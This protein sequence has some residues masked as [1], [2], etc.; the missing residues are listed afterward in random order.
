[1]PP[2]KTGVAAFW[3]NT[4]F[5]KGLNQFVQGLAK[6]GQ[7]AGSSGGAAGGIKQFTEAG[8][9]SSG[10][11]TQQI[12]LGVLLGNIYTRLA[13][14]VL[15]A[16]KSLFE[17]GKGAVVAAARVQTLGLVAQLL[18]QRAGYTEQQINDQTAA[19]KALG[20]QTDVA[21]GLQAQFARYN[22]DLAQATELARVAQ[23]AAVLSNENSS[24]ALDGLLQ[25]II[26]YNQRILRTHGLNVD[27]SNAQD[28]LAASLGKTTD[29]LTEQEKVQAALNGV[30]QAGKAIYGVY[31]TA[32]QTAGKQAKSLERLFYELKIT[33]G[34][35]FLSAFS[36]VI[37]ALTSLVKGFTAAISEGGKLYPVITTLGAIANI[38][39]GGIKNLADAIGGWLSDAANTAENKVSGIANEAINWG[40]N[41][42]INLATGLI[43]GAA[44]AI[45]AAL[46]WI[47]DLI[48]SWLQPG[49][50]PK[51]LPDLNKYGQ[52]TMEEYLKS[53]ST[54]DFSALNAIQ[55]QM[56]SVFGLL[57]DQGKLAKEQMGPLFASISKDIIKAMS[58]GNVDESLFKKIKDA[59]GQ[60]GDEL[61][62]LARKQI[63]LAQ[64]EEKVKAAE[65]ALQDA[66]KRQAEAGKQVN[67]LT[68][69]Y[70]RMLRGGASAEELAAQKAKI[71][72]SVQARDAAAEEA[73]QAQTNLDAAKEN[74]DVLKEQAQLQSELLQQLIELA[75]AKVQP[76]EPTTP[77]GGGAGGGTPPGGTSFQPPE[78]PDLSNLEDT[79]GATVDRIK[80]NILD[81]LGNV[82]SELVAMW[83]ERMGPSM[84]KLSAAWEA[85]KTAVAPVVA[86]LKQKW[87]EFYN[88]LINAVPQFLENVKGWWAKHGGNLIEIGQ[89]LWKNL[90]GGL[91]RMWQNIQ[92]IWE[93]YGGD[94]WQ[95]M[96]DVWALIV[97]IVENGMENIGSFIDLISALIKGDWAG[98]WEAVKSIAATGWENIKA[99]LKLAWDVI[100]LAFKIV[101]DY[102][103][104]YWGNIWNGIKSVAT[105]IWGAIVSA[106]TTIWNTII[107]AITSAI[108][109][110]K[111][112]LETAWN[113]ILLTATTIWNGI[114]TFFAGIWL[115]I[116]TA[117]QTAVDAVSGIL[118]AAWDT[119]KLAVETVWNGINTFLTDLIN[120]IFVWM[121][122]SL[123]EQKALWS[124]RLDKIWLIISTIWTRIKDWIIEK[125]GEAKTW[126][127]TNL[128]ALKTILDGIWTSIQTAA[129]T[130]WNA[131]STTAT[132]I[133]DTIKKTIT[134]VVD[135][136]KTWL[137]TTWANIQTAAETVWGLISGSAT[138][139]WTAIQGAIAGP[140][141]T[142]V[143]WL[144]IQWGEIQTTA[145]RIWGTI[146]TAISGVVQGIYN[147]VTRIL[148]SIAGA[149]G[150]YI[151][152]MVQAGKDLIQGL[153]NGVGQMA[154]ALLKAVGQLVD[155]AIDY[156]L[157]KLG[158]PHSPSWITIKAGKD[159]MAGLE[160][161]IKLTSELPKNALQDAL[162][163]MIPS[164]PIPVQNG[165]SYQTLNMTMN[166]TLANGMDVF[167]FNRM[168]ERSVAK[169]F[170]R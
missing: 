128:N 25:G 27:M 134:T 130:V 153:I 44:S 141:T 48:K 53:F 16:A 82:W 55:G 91:T 168:V 115:G 88:W 106:A 63:E 58:T 62:D 99:V 10:S 31:E 43:Q 42:A 118:S 92:K 86:W 61:A 157:D 114:V 78:M 9:Q 144:G 166:N 64:A 148:G 113:N 12:G 120:G 17:Y 133:W 96:K 165:P 14:A 167:L 143:T 73:D 100:K 93:R 119:I 89:W 18:G 161:G 65:L 142:V 45:T 90:V 26:T 8:N 107:T 124:D 154:G 70:N 39:T 57:V 29:Q 69:E 20:I 11:M 146:T 94:I 4:D 151:N 74:I 7:S 98:V 33:I 28:Q 140:I 122:T 34:Q 101:L 2:V 30:L 72:A 81:K 111:L 59:G 104:W 131:L 85:L 24:E 35:P 125:V 51:I 21:L 158:V 129:V 75:Q 60:Y 116:Q 152:N 156:I 109:A 49:S 3:D 160:K 83:N 132:T 102:L 41:I 159:V 164:A 68:M 136:I 135:A 19:I 66:R 139:L 105:T 155:D 71:D 147:E 40:A 110:V 103:K 117:F 169:A 76:Q 38:V 108:E 112:W 54:A 97:T 87:S 121:G 23:D 95:I 79:L 36:N 1:M 15:D 126:L 170:R 6:A 163:K 13:T 77:G 5:V 52:A 37:L 145:E 162:D 127:E 123:D 22:L 56:R 80:Q 138:R 67:K 137:D 47:A 149:A 50:P 32:Q 46:Q 84:A 150:G